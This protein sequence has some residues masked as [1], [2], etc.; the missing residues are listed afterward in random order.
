MVSRFEQGFGIFCRLDAVAGYYV[1][2]QAVG[3]LMLE[4]DRRPHGWK[5]FAINYAYLRDIFFRHQTDTAG[6]NYSPSDS[7]L[8]TPNSK[9][10]THPCPQRLA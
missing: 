7:E 8:E 6:Q 1:V 3:H 4:V 5:G 2:R 9:L 10:I